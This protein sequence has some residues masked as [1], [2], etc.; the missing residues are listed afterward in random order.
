ME[1][2]PGEF[3]F[4]PPAAMDFLGAQAA[5]LTGMGAIA[6][7]LAMEER[8]LCVH[9]DGRSEN[10]LEH[11]GMLIKTAITLAQ[12]F[13]PHLDISKVA[14]YA[15]VHDDSEAYV[16]DTSTVEITA[17]ELRAK[18]EREQLAEEQIEKDF[19]H[20]VPSYVAD[21]KT[22]SKQIEPEARFVRLVDKAMTCLIHF[23]NEGEALRAEYTREQEKVL[24]KARITRLSQEYPEF[25]GVLNAIAELQKYIL[26]NFFEDESVPA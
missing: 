15:A 1:S 18:A 21:I 13:Y 10:V 3:L 12:E 17:D 24:Q 6:S 7:R 25:P 16:G 20:L 11:T 9:P 26:D 19:G 14:R 8:T 22:Y 4:R 23:P 2:K 5:L